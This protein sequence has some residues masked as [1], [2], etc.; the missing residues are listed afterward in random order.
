MTLL[1]ITKQTKN[2]W[3]NIIIYYLK[4]TDLETKISGKLRSLK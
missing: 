1:E 4:W 3:Q 2:R